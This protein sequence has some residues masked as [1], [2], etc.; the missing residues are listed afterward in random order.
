[1]S[2]A[3]IA[4]I[5]VDASNFNVFPSQIEALHAIACENFTK[6]YSAVVVGSVSA[7]YVGD[8]PENIWKSLGYKVK[9]PVRGEDQ[10][11]WLFNV[12]DTIVATM[13]NDI[14]EVDFPE[15][16]PSIRCT[17]AVASLTSRADHVMVLLSGDGNDNDGWP[18]LFG[19]IEKV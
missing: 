18:S 8:P 16:I 3:K 13:L 9:F 10:P 19:A 7:K 2:S 15:G 17:A 6:F 12:D 5:F 11:E 14:L 4:H 1:M